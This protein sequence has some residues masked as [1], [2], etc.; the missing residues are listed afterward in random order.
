MNH[1]AG[2]L[3]LVFRFYTPLDVLVFIRF[4]YFNF[5]LIYSHTMSSS[6]FSGRCGVVRFGSLRIGGL[7]GIWKG[8]D[9]KTGF[10]ERAPFDDTTLR[11]VF[12]IRFATH[13]GILVRQLIFCAFTRKNLL[14]SRHE[15]APSP[16]SC[17]DNSLCGNCY[18]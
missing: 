1:F 14:N 2:L 15:H 7:S 18:K 4:L 17:I 3:C 13:S 8:Y 16:F 6:Y 9:Y 12:H 5:S 11:S 10:H